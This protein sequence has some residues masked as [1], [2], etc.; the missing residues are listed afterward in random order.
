MPGCGG[1]PPLPQ[2]WPVA[3]D[4]A[5]AAADA[6]EASRI[7]RL[8]IVGHSL[9]CLVAGAIAAEFPALVDRVAF[10]SPALGHRTPV[11][12]PLPPPAQSR[13]D[14]FQ[15]LGADGVARA[16]GQLL[17]APQNRTPQLISR[18]E[19]GLAALQMPGYGQSTRML[20]S[21]DLV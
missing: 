9:G 7:S 4:F 13:I 2:H 19:A 1:S 18:V 16:R 8:R 17:L 14:D 15:R 20:A 12:T 3:R 6:A 10:V 5:Q 11:G 21:G